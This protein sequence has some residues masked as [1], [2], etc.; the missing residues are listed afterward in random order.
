MCFVPLW[1]TLMRLR[2]AQKRKSHQRQLV[3]GSDPFYKE[4]RN[5]SAQSHQRQLVVGSDPFYKWLIPLLRRAACS[6]L[7]GHALVRKDL[8]HPLT[9]VSGISKARRLCVVL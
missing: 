8:N 2:F 1:L 4:V 3:D 5:V 9:A 6:A 7:S